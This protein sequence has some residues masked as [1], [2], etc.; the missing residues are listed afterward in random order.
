M[1]SKMIFPTVLS[2]IVGLPLH[3]SAQPTDG[4]LR[5]QQVLMFSRH[6]LRA[7]LADNGSVL[8]QS[9]RKPW[10]QWE[11]PGGHLTAKGGVLEVYMGHYTRAW[12]AQ[13]GLAKKSECPAPDDVLVYANSL[14][15]TVA[16]AQFFVA[17]AFP[18]C[19]IAVTHQRKMGAMDPTFNPVV[20]DGSE[21]FNRSALAAMKSVEETLRLRSAYEHLE[22]IIDYKSAAACEGKA[23]CSLSGGMP[24]KFS[25]V[26]GKEPGV[27]GPLKVGNSLVDAFT[28]QYYQG[29]PEAQIAW[30]QITTPEQWRALSEIKNGYQDALFTS[31]LMAREVA[32]PLLAYIRKSMI[33]Q[34][35]TRA[36]K[37]ILMVGHDS[38]VAS[39]LSALDFK[40]YD[41]PEQNEKTPIGG[42]VVFQRWHDGRNNK[43]LM[44][45]EY[46][47]QSAR[48]LRDAQPLNMEN[49]PKRVV[50]QM[51]ACPVDADGYCAWE[52]FVQALNRA[53]KET[54]AP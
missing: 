40:A 54:A 48:Q 53:Q 3:V 6:N 46:V 2:V 42:M 35:K 52:A 20:A 18:G 10:P 27:S 16:T 30:G 36:P 28:L 32:A 39:L 21:A 41:L 47:Y 14:Q 22:K 5:L 43:A 9:T 51:N 15:R 1:I 8:E 13:Q 25:A 26:S 37:V 24:N 44:K 50:L 29:F 12:L 17:G 4:S 11:V 34:D 7:P 49:P 19:E 33:D 45:A 31:P 23:D 38:N